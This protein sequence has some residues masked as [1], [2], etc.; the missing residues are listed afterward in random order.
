MS[1]LSKQYVI[2]LS[3]A[4]TMFFDKNYTKKFLLEWNGSHDWH[5]TSQKK[6]SYFEDHQYKLTDGIMTGV[7][8]HKNKE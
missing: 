4:K 8:I 3:L 5:P 2:F 1:T 7:V 6:E